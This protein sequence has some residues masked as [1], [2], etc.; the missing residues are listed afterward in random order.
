[1]QAIYNFGKVEF[2]HCAQKNF[3]NHKKTLKQKFIQ[4]HSDK[5][6]LN[7]LKDNFTICIVDKLKK[8]YALVCKHLY[9]HKLYEELN[10]DSYSSVSTSI[11]NIFNTHRIYNS[12]HNFEHINRLPYLYATPKLHNK[13]I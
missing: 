8:N 13:K 12:K 9:K 10:S 2:C 5:Q 11:D 1:M 6:F 4:V 3:H 7:I